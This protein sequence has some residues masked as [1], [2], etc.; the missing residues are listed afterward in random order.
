[1]SR[2]F[3]TRNLAYLRTLPSYA[4]SYTRPPL[5]RP[6]FECPSA[7][8]HIV[9]PGVNL[10]HKRLVSSN[11]HDRPVD[12]GIPRDKKQS[13]RHR[14]ASNYGGDSMDAQARF[15]NALERKDVAEAWSSFEVLRAT[16]P[17]ALKVKNLESLLCLLHKSFL[18]NKS[19]K[20][21]ELK[22]VIQ[23]YGYN[24]G[25][26]DYNELIKT[27]L[28]ENHIEEACTIFEELKNIG[29]QI[30]CVE[31]THLLLTLFL[32]DKG[33]EAYNIYKQFPKVNATLSGSD[34]IRILQA[35]GKKG[36]LSESEDVFNDFEKSGLNVQLG[37]IP[38]NILI[39]SYRKQGL[40]DHAIAVF[41][42]MRRR[43]VEP[44]IMTY[45][46]MI[47]TMLE[48]NRLSEAKELLRELQ[49]KS[50]PKILEANPQFITILMQYYSRAGEHQNVVNLFATTLMWRDETSQNIAMNVLLDS[51]GFN[52]NLDNVKATWRLIFESGGNMDPNHYTTLI[53][54]MLR[55]GG[56]EDAIEVVEKTMPAMRVIPDAKTFIT[57]FSGLK[58][59]D[60][61]KL[62]NVA[63]NRLKK[64]YPHLN[65]KML[66]DETLI[67]KVFSK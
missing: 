34:Y 51:A 40:T 48:V 47:M 16:R 32:N 59:K 58:I 46:V 15:V 50:D 31:Y 63:M 41:E 42:V 19:Q 64:V 3:T 37:E 7:Q 29:L 30:T 38:Y 1:M 26:A 36:M 27:L 35:M 4:I 28:N 61:G 17:E 22:N 25:A 18:P 2:L 66:T 20:Y 21:L 53:E 9:R 6:R 49:S 14:N 23:Q 56:A 5:F 11:L 67:K 10:N 65:F 60:N 39:N 54:G 12:K 55:Q 8:I 43:H 24:I 57:L 33:A 62:V 52:T 13:L 44:D 45:C